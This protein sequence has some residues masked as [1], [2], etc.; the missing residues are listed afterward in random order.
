M[1]RDWIDALLRPEVPLREVGP[2]LYSVLA[3]AE[4]GAPYDGHAA[5]YDRMV[6]SPTYMRI[7]WG[8]SRAENANFIASAFGAGDGPILDVAA[9][10]CVDSAA[11]YAETSRPTIVL[12][13]S[14]AMLEH[15]RE[16]LIRL[17]GQV[18]DHVVFLQA[19]AAETP[20]RPGAV[21]TILCHGAYHVF[22]ETA[23]IVQ[24]WRRLLPPGGGVFVSS[25]T[26]GRFLGDRYLALL[27][28]AGGIEKP[29]TT[30]AFVAQLGAE[31][32]AEISFEVKG[33]FTYAR[34]LCSD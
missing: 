34:A 29:R 7:A 19:D 17:A 27:H 12:D 28:R 24:E 10:S 15:G 11:S 8:L 14:V 9:G 32:G 21:E 2:A 30:D 18:P 13:R 33:N 4:V 3:P 25:L 5:A 16:R 1:N 23:P 20:L 6:S 31:L 22:P 26:L